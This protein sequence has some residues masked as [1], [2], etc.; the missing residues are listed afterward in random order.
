MKE[1]ATELAPMLQLFFRAS[2]DQGYLP[3]EWKSANVVPIFKKGEKNSAE[4][5]RPVSLTSVTCKMLEHIIGS[6]IMKHLDHHKILND[7]QHGFRK[8]RSCES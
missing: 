3:K 6:S 5:Y 2:L 4:N 1:L 7:A 8:Q